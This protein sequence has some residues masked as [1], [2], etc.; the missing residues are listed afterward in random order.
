SL[1]VVGIEDLVQAVRQRGYGVDGGERARRVDEG[2]QQLR[3]VESGYVDGAHGRTV[4]AALAS[5]SSRATSAA[6]RSPNTPGSVTIPRPSRANRVSGASDF[7]IARP[8]SSPLRIFIIVSPL[9][10]HLRAREHVLVFGCPVPR[11]LQEM[12]NPA[13]VLIH[14]VPLVQPAQQPADVLEV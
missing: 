8:T 5:R 3:L 14:Q 7:Q 1:V 10:W 6:G 2:H 12:E 9:L 13:Q 4:L 11:L